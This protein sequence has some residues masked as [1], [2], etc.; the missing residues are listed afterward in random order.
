KIYGSGT[1]SIKNSQIS[2]NYEEVIKVTVLEDGVAIIENN[3]LSSESDRIQ[4]VSTPGTDTESYTL[5]FQNN[6][7]YNS[8]HGT[9]LGIFNKKGKIIFNNNTI[10]DYSHAQG[11]LIGIITDS[12]ENQFYFNNVTGNTIEYN[13][14][15]NFTC[16][17]FIY[18]DINI[19]RN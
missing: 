1:Y 3:T 8:S 9:P 15:M 16:T 11:I 5:I 17:L 10:F 12:S 14:D 19:D 4:I 6:I 7:I 18:G 13:P 2:N